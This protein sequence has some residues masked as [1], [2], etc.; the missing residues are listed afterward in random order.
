[1]APAC[2]LYGQ[3]LCSHIS[4]SNDRSSGC[5]PDERSNANDS[6]A[7]STFIAGRS[8]S[9]FDHFNLSGCYPNSGANTGYHTKNG[10]NSINIRTVVSL[11]AFSG[12]NLYELTFFKL[13]YLPWPLRTNQPLR[14]GKPEIGSGIKFFFQQ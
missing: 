6:L 10:S 9:G 2:W 14:Y 5:F 8:R 7:I 12:N 11:D 13:S 1:M 4:I 3:K